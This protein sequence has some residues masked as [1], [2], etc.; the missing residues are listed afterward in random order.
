MGG[1]Y[2]AYAISRRTF[3][4]GPIS[5]R[6][7]LSRT[8]LEGRPTA[9]VRLATAVNALLIVLVACGIVGA[10]SLAVAARA[11][12]R[13]QREYDAKVGLDVAGLVQLLPPHLLAR[14]YTMYLLAPHGPHLSVGLVYEDP[15]PRRGNPANVG[16][17][18]DAD[19]GALLSIHEDGI[20]LGYK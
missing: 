17:V 9:H 16:L 11:N 13:R 12:K 3:E 2:V 1:F 8:S 19:T 20:G 18:F 6:M 10:A 4:E 14:E 7:P 5:A 15:Q